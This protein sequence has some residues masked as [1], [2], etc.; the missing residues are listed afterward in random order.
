MSQ[1]REKIEYLDAL[2]STRFKYTREQLDERFQLKFKQS[3]KRIFFNYI[4]ILKEE[5]APLKTEYD[6]TKFGKTL[7]FYDEV[8]SLTKNPLKSEHLQKVKTA[9]TILKQVEGLPQTDELTALIAMVESQTNLKTVDNQP[10]V[11][12]DHR[13][14]SDGI[15]WISKLYKW[16]EEKTVLELVYRPYPQD[17]LDYE[18]IQGKK[19][20]F[21]PYFLKESQRYWYLFGLNQVTQTIQNYEL[22]RIV[23][24]KAASGFVFC[25]ARFPFKTYF[26]DVIGVTK[27][28]NYELQLYRIR[29]SKAIAPY[30]KSR[31]LH[32]SQTWGEEAENGVIFEFKL[33]WNYEW[34]NLILHYGKNVEVLEPIAFRMSIQQI[35]KDTLALYEA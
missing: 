21:H 11:L 24:V 29:V 14:S 31:K 23:S 22:D 3:L 12:L 10:I 27:F 20:Y 17:A 33:R 28:G 16:I 4:Q 9:L 6:K 18:R 2:F 26:D 13:P 19:V 5:G 25:P 32:A 30:W 35:L 7:Y 1:K 8:F 15:R 34:Q